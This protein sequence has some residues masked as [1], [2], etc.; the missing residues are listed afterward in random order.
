[1]VTG[2]SSG[3]GRAMA[4]AFAGHGAFVVNADVQPEPREGGTA[5]DEMIRA[6]NGECCFLRT[7]VSCVEDVER[8]VKAAAG[9]TGRI[10][11]LVNNAMF[12]GTHN[13]AVLDTREEDWDAM[14]N[15]GLRG[16]FLCCR[17]TLRQMLAQEQRAELR[18]RII[19][20]ASQVAF[21]GSPGSFTSNTIKGAVVAMTRQL[22]VEFAESGITVNAIA[23]GRIPTDNSDPPEVA[24]HARLR[25]PVPRVGL[26]GDVAN[27]AV[28]LASDAATFMT[29]ATV[30]V[31]GGWLAAF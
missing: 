9:R 10:D 22:A 8:L 5:T 19:N 16:V 17:H 14:M 28:F 12:Y 26:P 6:A 31:D 20:I 25:A 21:L 4:L 15:V 11:V 23:P 24:E 27:L 1:M 29:G 2:A 7:D 30:P 3:I 18:G 13:G